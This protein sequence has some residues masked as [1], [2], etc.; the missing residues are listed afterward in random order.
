MKDNKSVNYEWYKEYGLFNK[1]GS[2]FR[3]GEIGDWL[4]Y[5]SKDMSVIFD[6]TIE[7]NL[8]EKFNFNYGI[9]DDILVKIYKDYDENNSIKK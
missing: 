6:K 5:F 7:K 9:N 4:N 8:K 1:N 3:K 2:F